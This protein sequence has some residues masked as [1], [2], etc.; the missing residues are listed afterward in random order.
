MGGAPFGFGFAAGSDFVAG[1]TLLAAWRAA[2]GAFLGT[3]VAPLLPL[4]GWGGP[5][6]G[7]I[8]F[9][10][11]TACMSL[12][13]SSSLTSGLERALGLDAGAG[14]TEATEESGH[15]SK[16]GLGACDGCDGLGWGAAAF[17]APRTAA[18]AAGLSKKL[19]PRFAIAA[20]SSQGSSCLD[21]SSGPS[22]TFSASAGM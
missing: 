8:N 9:F 19:V 20:A 7:S 2:G 17:L 4:L 5:S 15:S 11:W 1:M 3:V 10:E 13:M 21:P 12:A 22:T 6:T 14:A 16:P 18:G